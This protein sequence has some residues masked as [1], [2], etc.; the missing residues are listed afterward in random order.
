MKN[1]FWFF[2]LLPLATL[3]Q[4]TDD[5]TDGDFTNN[6]AWAGDVSLFAISNSTAIPA[7]LRPSLRLNASAAGTSSLYLTTP[8]A[9][10]NNY[11][12]QFWV[13]ISF[14]PTS[15]NFARVYLVSDSS[16]LKA[17]LNGY[18]VQIGEIN[19]KIGLCKQTGI[20][21]QEIITGSIANL[22][23]SS[24][25]LR[26]KV[27]RDSSG[28]WTLYSD[29]TGGT[30]FQAEGTVTDTT[31]QTSSFFGVY[32]KYTLTNIQNFYFDD[33]YIGQPGVDATPPAISSVMV[34]SQNSLDILFSENVE[35]LSAESTVNY[36]VNNSI[37]NPV[38]ATRDT[39]NNSLVHLVFA[40]NF[41]TG[42]TDSLYIYNVKDL[43]DN[44]ITVVDTTFTYLN[45][46]PTISS[47]SVL[48][49][50]TLDVLFSENVDQATSETLTNY[51]VNN[52]IGNPSNANRD[53]GNNSLVHL[54]FGT[55][56]TSG[57]TDT[58]YVYNVKGL[59]DN[60]I[61]VATAVFTYLDI[62]DS[63]SDNFD[64]GDFTANPVW[65]GEGIDSLFHI[66]S[67]SGN[68]ML[69]S[70]GSS[71]A[72]FYIS[73]PVAYHDSMEWDFYIRENFSPSSS[74]NTKVYLMSDASDLKNSVTGYYLLFGE[75]LS[76]DVVRLYRQNGTSS[77]LVCSG[78]TNISASFA[79]KIKVKKSIAGLWSIY[80][81]QPQSSNYTMEAAGV[82]NS[83]VNSMYFGLLVKR[84]SSNAKNFY[85]DD[86]YVGLPLVDHS[87]PS[88]ASLSVISQNSLDILFS[89]AV[90]Q[91]SSETTSNYLVDN[92]V[93]NPATATRDTAYSSLVHLVFGNSFPDGLTDTLYVFN[94][95]DLAGNSSDTAFATFFYSNIPS[96][97]DDHFNDGNFNSNPIWAGD[98]SLFTVYDNS[99]NY[100][101]R[102]N[103]TVPKTTYLYTRVGLQDT[104]EWRFYIK[105]NFSPSSTSYARVFLAA[106]NGTFTG[107]VNG[108]FLQFGEANATDVIRLYRIDG[109]A[110]TLICSGTTNIANA[111]ALKV[112]V[113][114]DATGL[115]KIYTAAPTSDLYNFEGSGTDTVYT[116]TTYF[117]VLCKFSTTNYA[118]E[119]YFDDFYAGPVIPDTTIPSIVSVNVT[120]SNSVDITFSEFVDLVSAQDTLNYF[121]NH[122]AGAP[123]SAIRDAV[124]NAV[125][126]LAFPNN[127]LDGTY[128]T[129]SVL[130]V[131]DLNGNAIDSAVYSFS[132]TVAPT[133]INEHFTDGEFFSNPTWN[134]DVG[135]FMVDPQM[136]LELF[137]ASD[138]Y[139]TS[140]LSTPV[141]ITLDSMEWQVS[142]K[143]M[144]SPS[145]N[146]YTRFYLMSDNADLKKSL[147]GYYLQMG[148]NGSGDAVELYRQDGNTSTVVCRGT[149]GQVAVNPNVRIKIKHKQSGE[150]L[151]SADSSGNMNFQY[152][153]EGFDSTYKYRLFNLGP[154]CRYSSSYTEGKFFFDDIYAGPVIKDTIP[155]VLENIIF[156]DS[157]H[158]ELLFSE[159]INPA[160]GSNVSNYFVNK[161]YGNPVSADMN[162]SNY[163]IVYLSYNNPFLQDTVYTITISNIRDIEGNLISAPIVRNFSYHEIQPYDIV[164]N[165]IM[166]DPS[167][168]VQLP[169][170]EYIEL[171]NTTHFD[172]DLNGWHITVGSSVKTFPQYK[173]AADS[174][175]IVTAVDNEFAFHSYGRTV[176]LLSSDVLTNTGATVILSN[177]ENATISTVTYSDTW[178]RNNT[179]KD[180]GWSL[181]QIDPS[182][183]CGGEDNWI[184]S[185]DLKGG[186]PG[187]KNSVFASNLD[188]VPPQLLHAVLLSANDSL[189]LFFSEP[190]N[191]DHLTGS[192][193]TVD[194]SVGNPVEIIPEGP[195]NTSVILRFAQAFQSGII[196]TITVS[197]Q[198]SDCVGNHLASDNS[199]KFAIS[200][201]VDNPL[202]IVINEILFN[203]NDNGVDYIEI[204]NR[205][206]KIIDLKNVRL[207]TRSSTSF[208]LETMYETAKEGHLIFPGDYLVLTTDP[209]I[210]MQQYYTPNPKNFVRM[211]S[212]P[213][214]GNTSDEVALVNKSLSIIDD[215]AY[216]EKMQYPLLTSFKGIALERVNF[217]RPTNDKTNWH[218][219]AELHFGY[220]T[221]TYKNSQYLDILQVNDEIIITPEVFSPDND[222]YNDLL[223]IGYKF[224]EADNTANVTIFDA[225]GR[226]VKKLISNE[227]LATTGTF[228]WDGLDEGNNKAE[229]GIYLIYIEIFDLQG[230]V[231]KYKK[232]CVVASKLR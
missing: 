49:N 206:E 228:I 194:N 187:T 118:H 110:T 227:L 60:P 42:V 202:D 184:A 44:A 127:F 200:Q 219:A 15:G 149:D 168:P 53:A 69:Q 148:E 133:V 18:Y 204:Y 19:D 217:D 172:I 12:W 72:T 5:F 25:M 65:I 171:F 9:N 152:Q 37:G 225:K 189:R 86:F 23:V 230:K 140:Y 153:A 101:L 29:V 163:S 80:S 85:F 231:K 208:Q 164:I 181:E 145:S 124:N 120:S 14:N 76:G 54:V 179:K 180:G 122:G 10:L 50:H 114:K 28:L 95:S 41:I 59:T 117:G 63:I 116:N 1:I 32:C 135:D 4:I 67:V 56:F 213:S 62:P 175:L 71:A 169:E 196:Y 138:G 191:A 13:K 195:Q 70:W 205:S 58:L 66:S 182:N 6:P 17:S 201:P 20:T 222:G 136:R 221:P 232:T 98:D 79:L 113:T 185:A 167:P 73:T 156:I 64:D 35:Q 212:M 159:N 51:F 197:N 27:T 102:L 45:N 214:I 129:L 134:G 173:I 48:S 126:H 90:D 16:D 46:P 83:I 55:N 203:P 81:A 112:R 100:M 183:P 11:E 77:T 162:L 224:N 21:T 143:L 88:I 141:N 157:T 30:S 131:Q 151:I 132:Y 92:S 74:N 84:T 106:D 123:N 192:M 165:E 47:V 33:F 160:L 188:I 89:E 31:Y 87:A 107:S 97:L 125:V 186:T 199:A 166:T 128:Y 229:I 210:V 99:G 82:D 43:S 142:V 26:I 104:M 93:G 61:T 170:I 223:T 57:V 109:T 39:G 154:Y 209:D 190:V 155:P 119:F 215:L 178:Y 158:L 75:D 216:D 150:W 52:G 111:F 68:N 36:F 24:S 174:F 40:N 8:A 207:T 2:L 121:I 198:L 139:D 96:M 78:V 146:N 108:Y 3:A 226:L 115:W 7:N 91:V 161:G 105:L 218:S 147:H 137:T 34:L 94:V 176:G 22:N 103:G 193:F 130:N 144:F 177:D 211:S 38:S 220:G